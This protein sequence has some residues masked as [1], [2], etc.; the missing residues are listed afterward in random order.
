MFQ[1]HHL[2]ELYIGGLTSWC[3]Q[4]SIRVLPILLILVRK[5]YHNLDKIVSLRTAVCKNQTNSK[6][7]GKGGKLDFFHALMRYFF[8]GEINILSFQRYRLNANC[9]QNPLK[10]SFEALNYY[11]GLKPRL[12][13]QIILVSLK[14]TSFTT[15]KY[16]VKWSGVLVCYFCYTK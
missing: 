16:L 15:S 9:N 10:P 8:F 7:G 5:F 12:E 14:Q 4:A 3:G 11:T 2:I 1:W 13:K 6:F